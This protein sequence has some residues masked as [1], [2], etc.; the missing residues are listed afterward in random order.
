M[1]YRQPSYTYIVYNDNNTNNNND[2]RADAGQLNGLLTHV[3]ALIVLE[4]RG[5]LGPGNFVLPT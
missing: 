3:R 2:K 1:L 4:D 5:I